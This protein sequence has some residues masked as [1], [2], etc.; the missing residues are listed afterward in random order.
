M[1]DRLERGVVEKAGDDQIG[2]ADGRNGIGRDGDPLLRERPRLVGIAIPD[3]QFV[4]RGAGKAIRH[5][6]AHPAESEE[7]DFHWLCS[8]CSCDGLERRP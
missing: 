1:E 6:R 2:V 5:A 8:G 7:G 4:L 3:R